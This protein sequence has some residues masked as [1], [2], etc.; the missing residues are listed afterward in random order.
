MDWANSLSHLD[1]SRNSYHR[2]Q[3]CSPGDNM[4]YVMGAFGIKGVTRRVYSKAELQG[5][6]DILGYTLTSGISTGITKTNHL[7][8]SSKMS[9][10]TYDAIYNEDYEFTGFPDKIPADTILTN[11]SGAKWVIRLSADTSLHDADGDTIRVYPGSLVNFRGAGNGGNNHVQLTLSADGRTITYIPRHNFA[12]RCQFGYNIWDGKEKGAF[13]LHTVDV[14]RGNNVFAAKGENYVMNGNFEEGTEVKIKG[15]AESVPNASIMMGEQREGHLFGQHFGDGHPRDYFMNGWVPFGSGV[16]IK[17]A[18]AACDSSATLTY[19]FGSQTSNSFPSPERPLQPGD[20]GNRYQIIR[21]NCGGYFNLK[22]PLAHCNKYRLSFDFYAD[23]VTYDRR[24]KFVIGFLSDQYSRIDTVT[25]RSAPNPRLL[26][27]L[28]PDVKMIVRSGWVHY[29]MTFRYCNDTAA[30][31]LFIRS[32]KNGEQGFLDNLSI[33]E[34]TVETS[35]TIADSVL[36]PCGNRRLYAR[37]SNWAQYRCSDSTGKPLPVTWTAKGIIVGTDSFLYASPKDTTT[38]IATATDGCNSYTDSI[39]VAPATGPVVAVKDTAACSGDSV[40]LSLAVSGTHGAV[41]YSWTPATGLSCT[42]CPSPKA[43]PTVKTAYWVTVSD[44]SGC[45]KAA[46][47]VPVYALP[48]LHATDDSVC[49]GLYATLQVDGDTANRYRW[50]SYAVCDTCMHTTGYLCREPV[51]AEGE[52]CGDHD[53][54]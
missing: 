19:S 33:V 23:S 27:K 13:V 53:Q 26:A 14:G 16:C 54:Q 1:D 52:R 32:I 50:T 49:Y 34:D 12:G 43:A 15:V 22:S 5:F 9:S 4:D 48:V 44:D 35:L 29:E 10:V 28:N 31:V 41:T 30:N 17:N 18:Y 25:E 46:I 51:Q 11:D 2:K 38:Y 47:Y 39:R 42:S 21:D 24:S 20:T 40:L 36:S 37:I 7:S 8:W 45:S 3:R 6:T